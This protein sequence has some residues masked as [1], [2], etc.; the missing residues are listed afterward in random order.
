M[1]IPASTLIFEESMDPYDITDYVV[2]TSQI[3]EDL[4]AVD[5]YDI[6]IV[7]ESALLGLELGTGQ[8]APSIDIT[9]K[10]ITM[11]LQVEDAEQQNAQFS[12]SGV[13]LPIEVNITT[14]SV[15]A[16]RKQRTV[17]VRVVQR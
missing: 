12:G 1:A 9:N 11:W 17:A 7:A 6:N 13:L 8:Y 3:L 16:R 5:D 10:L 15:P 14:N 4:E 2:D